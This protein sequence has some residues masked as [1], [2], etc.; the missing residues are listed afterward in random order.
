MTSFAIPLGSRSERVWATS[1]SSTVEYRSTFSAGDI[2]GVV[3]SAGVSVFVASSLDDAYRSMVAS[4]DDD[5]S[6]WIKASYLGAAES[7]RDD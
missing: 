5:E 7:W 1:S 3:D 2:R 6:A 4:M